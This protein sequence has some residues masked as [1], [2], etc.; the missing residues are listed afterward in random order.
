MKLATYII[1][2][3][4]VM[5]LTTGWVFATLHLPG[6]SELGTVGLSGFTLIFLPL[7]VINKARIIMHAEPY[8]QI[9]FILGVSSTMLIGLSAIFKI[10]HL[11]GAPTM[12][13]IGAFLFIFGFL[14]LFFFH[15]YKRAIA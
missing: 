2:L 5:A 10:M 4:S 13:M 14:P 12:L 1:G 6:A 11:Q 9:K 7:L 15:L 8:Q 3:L